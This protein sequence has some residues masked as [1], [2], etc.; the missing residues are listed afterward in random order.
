MPYKLSGRE[1]ED[2]A[3]VATG[4]AG[5]TGAL[6]M[7]RYTTLL[8]HDGNTRNAGPTEKNTMNTTK[9]SSR[10]SQFIEMTWPPY[11][12]RYSHYSTQNY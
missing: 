11:R 9:A 1:L 5:L 6:D 12:T 8:A 2:D 10:K 3:A 7:Y 4:T